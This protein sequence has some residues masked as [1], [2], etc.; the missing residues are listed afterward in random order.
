M[1]GINTFVYEKKSEMIF[2]SLTECVGIL[3][4]FWN[5]LSTVMEWGKYRSGSLTAVG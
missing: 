5:T 2:K 3:D 4:D 1:K